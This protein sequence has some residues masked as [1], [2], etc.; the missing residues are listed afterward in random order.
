MMLI[1]APLVMGSCGS[2]KAVADM[3]G[4]HTAA[5]GGKQDVSADAIVYKVADNKV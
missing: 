2:K 4:R 1:A 3:G 5:T